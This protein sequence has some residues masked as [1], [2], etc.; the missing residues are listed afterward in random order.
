MN[1]APYQPTRWTVTALTRYVRQMFETDYRL[2]D[3][4]IEGEVS[5]LRTPAS[6]HAYFT[7]KDASSQLRC[8][9]WRSEVASLRGDCR[10]TGIRSR[11]RQP[12]SLRST[13][14]IPAQVPGT[15]TRRAGRSLCPLR[16][17]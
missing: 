12:D 16:G 11:T 14:G 9:M 10:A 7:L 6:G 3:L 13:G 4:E 1:D 8:V 5:N 17:A 2:L 15:A